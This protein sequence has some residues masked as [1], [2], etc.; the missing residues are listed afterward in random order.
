MRLCRSAKW[1]G[2]SLHP[3]SPKIAGPPQSSRIAAT[4]NASC[5]APSTN[6]APTS[7]PTP[8][9]V[10]IAS[11]TT[12]R[13]SIG[14]VRLASTNS[15]TWPDAHGAV[16]H[17][18]EERVITKRLGNTQ[19]GDD[20]RS[21]RREHRD[22]NRPLLGI[23]HAREPR[24]ARPRPPQHGQREQPAADALPTPLIRHQRGALGEHEHEDEVEVELEWLDGFSLPQLCGQP[25]R[26]RSKGAAKRHAYFDTAHPPSVATG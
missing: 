17:R 16:G 9:A 19:G 14:S 22:P 13:R 8:T 20:D 10:L 4:Q 24:I 15:A 5:A 7:N 26:V 18:E 1:P 12:E 23:D 6:D 25:G 3:A 2:T 21:C 11:A